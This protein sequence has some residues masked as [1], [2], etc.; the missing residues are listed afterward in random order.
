MFRIL[1]ASTLAVAALASAT[2]AL[3]DTPATVAVTAAAPVVF[4]RD[5]VTYSYSVT[6]TPRGRLIRGEADGEPFSLTVTSTRVY[7]TMNGNPVE[8][9]RREV[10]RVAGTPLA[11]R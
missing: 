1:L 8:F 3:A 11:S 2:P 5:G 7:G 9:P 4:T 6:E 10:A